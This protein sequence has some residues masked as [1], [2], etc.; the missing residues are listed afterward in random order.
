MYS[1]EGIPAVT[2]WVKNP[3]V[4]DW[5]GNVVKLGCDDG[6]T[7]TN[8]IKF[9]ELKRKESACSDSGRCGLKD[10]GLLH[11][12]CWSRLQLRFSARP[13]N[14][15]MLPVWP[16]KKKKKYSDDEG[17]MSILV[18]HTPLIHWSSAHM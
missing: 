10:P 9:T 1:D 17:T 6:C 3:N 4:G 13:G 11:L 16:S 5:G 18:R 12:C 15:H 2:K 14:S 7:P 8:I